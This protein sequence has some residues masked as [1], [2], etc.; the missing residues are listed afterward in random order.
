MCIYNHIYFLFKIH[1]TLLEISIV[2]DLH[3]S[4]ICFKLHFITNNKCYYKLHLH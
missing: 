4:A 1:R 2:L 3:K